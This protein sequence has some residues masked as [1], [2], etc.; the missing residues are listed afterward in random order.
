MYFVVCTCFRFIVN[1]PT[2]VI[3]SRVHQK[4][5][6]KFLQSVVQDEIL[7][8][9]FNPIHHFETVPNSKKLQTTTEMWL[10]TLYQTIPTFN[11]LG[12]KKPFEKIVRKGENVGNQHF[13]L[14][15]QCFLPFSK[16][17]SNFHSHL[18]CRLHMLSIWTSLKI[19]RLVKS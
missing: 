1:G 17:I 6:H 12:Q 18:F 14:F 15:L 8:C 5:G 11:D 7:S 10:L 16:Q 4:T 3:R 19:C 9:K 13:L 2:F